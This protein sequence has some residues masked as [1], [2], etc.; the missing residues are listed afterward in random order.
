MMAIGLKRWLLTRL[1]WVGNLEVFSLPLSGLLLLPLNLLFVIRGSSF[2]SSNPNDLCVCVCVCV[3]LSFFSIPI[4]MIDQNSCVSLYRWIQVRYLFT[5]N[6]LGLSINGFGHLIR[7]IFEPPIV[8][9]ID[10]ASPPLLPLDW[11]QPRANSKIIRMIFGP[12]GN[13]WEKV[14]IQLYILTTTGTTADS[15]MMHHY[16]DYCG[17]W[18]LSTSMC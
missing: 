9:Y 5:I 18:L 8:H 11:W 13:S 12:I 10:L 2:P 15:G 3:S 14:L 16:C 4:R 17:R 7:P 6:L 1:S